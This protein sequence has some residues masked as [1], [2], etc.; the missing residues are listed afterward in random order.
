MEEFLEIRATQ[1]P[2]RA[3]DYLRPYARADGY[4][5]TGVGVVRF[6][7]KEL[8]ERLRRERKAAT[9]GKVSKPK[10]R[11]ECGRPRSSRWSRKS[12]GC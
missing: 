8:A 9:A 11:R 4:T 7:I 12:D 2:A 3:V 10:G 5:N 6:A 1:L